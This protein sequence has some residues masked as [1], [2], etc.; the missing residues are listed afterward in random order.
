MKIKEM[1][2]Y[3]GGIKYAND[4]HEYLALIGD[5]DYEWGCERDV[6]EE[7]ADGRYWEDTEWGVRIKSGKGVAIRTYAGGCSEYFSMGISISEAER[8]IREE[9]RCW[10]KNLGPAISIAD[11]NDPDPMHNNHF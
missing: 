1:P 9:G 11:H 8:L 3:F 6:S 5:F 7:L 10:F 2:K 4:K